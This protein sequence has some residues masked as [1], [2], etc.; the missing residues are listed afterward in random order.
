MFPMDQHIEAR[1]SFL[2]P[3][4]GGR[5]SP[6]SSGYRPQFHYA[7][8]AQV[9]DAQHTY[10]DVASVAPGDSVRAILCFTSPEYHRGRI[11]LGMPFE[12]REGAKLVGRGVVTRI[13]DL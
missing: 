2:R 7:S 8:D 3:D 11:E 1:I 13:I 5:H 12:I 9:W 4:E 6:V 10:P